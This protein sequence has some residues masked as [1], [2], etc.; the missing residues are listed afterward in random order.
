MKRALEMAAKD[1]RKHLTFE[2]KVKI[3]SYAEENCQVGIRI[4]GIGKIE[5]SAILSSIKAACE[6]KKCC[7]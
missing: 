5:L 7:I 4:Y 6:S 1:K 3:I 2:S